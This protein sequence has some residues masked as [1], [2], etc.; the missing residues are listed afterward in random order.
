MSSGVLTLMTWRDRAACL[1]TDPSLFFVGFTYEGGRGR[2][3]D[4]LKAPAMA[5]CGRCQVQVECLSYV[6]STGSANDFGIWGGMT[7]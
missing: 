4:S 3:V 1:D 7:T 2:S 6:M 5:I